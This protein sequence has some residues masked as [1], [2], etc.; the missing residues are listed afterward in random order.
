LLRHIDDPGLE[1]RQI[2]S[3]VRS[4]VRTETGGAQVPWESSSLEGDFYFRP[5]SVAPPPVAAVA[6]TPAAAAPA[7]VMPA[8][9]VAAPMAPASVIPVP[10]PPA[11]VARAPVTQAPAA[12]AQ[13]TP[14]PT[15]PTPVMAAPV[16][17]SAPQAPP[18]LKMAMAPPLPSTAGLPTT[19]RTLPKGESCDVRPW[20]GSSTGAGAATRM[21]VIEN[22]PACLGRFSGDPKVLSL[23]ANPAHGS[24]T[25]DGNT[26]FYTPFPGYT[27]ADQ[28]SIR[29]MP[30]GWLTVSVTVEPPEGRTP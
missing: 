2:L 24:V 1:I 4:E 20:S 22:G 27:G 30:L 17:Q 5:G 28:F 25:F 10:V 3:R 14:A 9:V 19:S 6:P 11:P 15:Q 18:P 26:F 21:R 29:T 16:M 8:P 12:L 13:A 7:R 23:T